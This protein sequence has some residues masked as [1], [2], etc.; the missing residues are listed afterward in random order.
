MTTV[1]YQSNINQ[2]NRNEQ[3]MRDQ[4][5]A[6]LVGWPTGFLFD[7]LVVSI[8]LFWFYLFFNTM[9]YITSISSLQSVQSNF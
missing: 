3:N 2:T 8:G 5:G 1:Q 6:D 9:E 7:E 4:E